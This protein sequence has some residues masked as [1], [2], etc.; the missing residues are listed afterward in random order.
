MK[1]ILSSSDKI[2]SKLK[3]SAKDKEGVRRK[4]AVRAEKLRLRVKPLAD[5]AK[6]K[7]IIRLK[8]A[9]TAKQLHIKAK[10]LASIAREREVVRRKLKVTAREKE[11]VR[12]KLAI[13][14]KKLVVVAKEKEVIRLKL[15]I[16]AKQLKE[17]STALKLKVHDLENEKSAALN[18]LED[19]GAEK[20]KVEVA[21][22]KEEAILFSI[23]DGLLATDEKGRIMLI[24]KKA[25]EL[26]GKKSAA[27]LGKLFSE[28][29]S[30]QDEKGETI[31][32]DKHPVNMALAKGTTTA[33]T[34][35]GSAYYYSRKDKAQFP[36]AIMVTPVMLL[37]KVIGT[38]EVFRDITREKEIDKAKNE[39]VSL[40]SHQLRTPTTG[41]N[42]YSEMLLEHKTGALNKKQDG[43]IRQIYHDNQRMIE[44]VNMLLNVSRI[45]LGTFALE[46]GA[47]NVANVADDV[48]AELKTQIK[49]KT[50]E[51]EKVY[52]K[53]APIIQSDEKLIRIVLQNLISNSVSYTP[54]NGK[55]SIKIEAMPNGVRVE[56]AD[57][58]LGIPQSAQEKI[59]TKFF[60]ADNARTMRPDGTG[61]GL[62]ITKSITKALGGT[63][64]FKSKE[65]K[66]T[67]F[68]VSIPSSH[69]VK[70]GK[71]LS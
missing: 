45:E 25:E 42:W 53:D 58:G 2:V 51:I 11:A 49:D 64:D 19:L 57:N 62:Y 15:A 13:T 52:A 66:G 69:V 29:V 28:V 39:F 56:V 71:R 65:G 41:I 20:S 30:I 60:R 12:I 47:T 22:A 37:G 27:V 18:V 67:T 8:L 68:F 40:A 38:I 10:Q 34:T 16:T 5:T 46:S 14:A 44:L 9:I 1:K 23:G 21:K 31:S 35:E 7:E 26:L 54:E 24:N 48:L 6:E 55:I 32:L 3:A 33:T 4:L 70:E 50:L 43:Y 36:V 17:S 61:L 59:Y 63:I